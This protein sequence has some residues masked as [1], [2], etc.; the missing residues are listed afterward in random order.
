MW[1]LG[2]LRKRGAQRVSC[3]YSSPSSSCFLSKVLP[4]IAFSFFLRDHFRVFLM[5]FVVFLQTLLAIF[6]GSMTLIS[7]PFPNR[8]SVI[9]NRKVAKNTTQFPTVMGKKFVI[10]LGAFPYD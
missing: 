5:F 8:I 1:F 9:S 10:T 3:D 7:T 2:V 4:D 6:G